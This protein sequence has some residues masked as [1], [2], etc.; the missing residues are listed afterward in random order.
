MKLLLDTHAFL[1]FI[2]DSPNLSSTAKDLLEDNANDL[3][4]SPANI[5]MLYS[6]C[7]AYS[8]SGE[9]PGFTQALLVL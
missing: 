2:N 8:G 1:W 4:L 5:W 3:Y 7:T 6:I 9:I